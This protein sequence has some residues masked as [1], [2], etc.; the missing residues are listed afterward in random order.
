M[1]P[2]R[3]RLEDLPLLVRFFVER[4]ARRMKK[5]IESVSSDSMD[6]LARYHWPGNL[7]ELENFVEHAVILS[8]GPTLQLPLAELNRAPS[9]Q[10]PIASANHSNLEE[11]ERSHILGA[12]RDARWVIGGAT[13]AAAKLGLKRTTLQSRM[14]KL[15]IERPV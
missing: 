14:K 5:R 7:R 1:P 6:A 3:E 10:S 12:L 15:G 8:S 13:G 2:L 4:S 9:V 11:A